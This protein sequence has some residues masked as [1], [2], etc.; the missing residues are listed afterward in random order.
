MHIVLLKSQRDLKLVS[1][2][3][4]QMGV[5]PSI[6]SSDGDATSVLYGHLVIHSSPRTDDQLRYCT[7]TVSIRSNVLVPDR[8]GHLTSV[9]DEHTKSI[10]QMFQLFSVIEKVHSISLVQNSFSSFPG[11]AW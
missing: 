8:L 2:L 9:D 6:V 5:G 7:K 4:A 11:N 3:S 1:T 10:L